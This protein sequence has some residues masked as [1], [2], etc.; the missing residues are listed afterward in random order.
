[1][2]YDLN[3]AEIY[4]FNGL[5]KES[6]EWEIELARSPYDQHPFLRVYRLQNN[7]KASRRRIAMCPLPID[8][9]VEHLL[10]C[11]GIAR[12]YYKLGLNYGRSGVTEKKS[13]DFR[14]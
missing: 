2:G 1:M 14:G 10:A 8:I 12:H 11:T 3:K 13:L 4:K 7:V 9:T 6:C 5:L